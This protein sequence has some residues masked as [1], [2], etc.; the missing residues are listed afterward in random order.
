MLML[1]LLIYDLTMLAIACTSIRITVHGIY[2]YILRPLTDFVALAKRR[3]SPKGKGYGVQALLSILEFITYSLYIYCLSFDGIDTLTTFQRWTSHALV[4]VNTRSVLFTSRTPTKVD[5][6][7]TYTPNDKTKVNFIWN[8][9]HIICRRAPSD[10]CC[11]IVF[12]FFFKGMHIPNIRLW[13][14]WAVRLFSRSLTI[15]NFG[16]NLRAHVVCNIAS[17]I[18]LFCNFLPNEKHNISSAIIMWSNLIK[19]EDIKNVRI[20]SYERRKIRNY[21]VFCY[22][23]ICILRNANPGNVWHTLSQKPQHNMKN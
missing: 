6:E 11:S 16:K 14:M 4:K 12:F 8:S 18:T 1:L 21:F 7:T 5:T 13:W 3:P 23:A 17:N 9:N 20:R 2:L 15:R 19:K 22:N 10:C